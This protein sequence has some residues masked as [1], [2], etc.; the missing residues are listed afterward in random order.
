M[1]WRIRISFFLVLLL[2]PWGVFFFSQVWRV[3]NLS[4]ESKYEVA[5][6]T[7]NQYLRSMGTLSADFSLNNKV[8]IRYV[9]ELEVDGQLYSVHRAAELNYE[10]QGGYVK[11]A[12]VEV[13]TSFSDNA[14]DE[15]VF[16]HVNPSFKKGDVTYSYGYRL[17]PSIWGVGFKDSPRAVCKLQF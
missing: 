6:F 15:L 2:L 11:Y 8:L 10:F 4:C 3:D 12:T 17:G 13:S 16:A 14:P 1:T 7:G 9:G 5:R